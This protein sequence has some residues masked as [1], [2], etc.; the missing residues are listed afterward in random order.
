MDA[1][2]EERL[3]VDG[4]HYVNEATLELLRR[5]L[6][7]DVRRSFWSWVGLPVGGAGILGVLY[8]LFAAIP[9]VVGD[10]IAGDPSIQS[11]MDQAV[12]EYLR[13]PDAGGEL[14]RRQVEQSARPLVTRAVSGYLAS[15]EGREVLQDGIDEAVTA[16]YDGD[17]GMQRVR[18]LVREHMASDAVRGQIRSAVVTALQPAVARLSDRIEDNLSALVAEIAPVPVAEQLDKGSLDRLHRFLDSA[19]AAEIAA[20]G[21]PVTLGLG[22][23]RGPR[24]AAFAI[25]EH[26]DALR[27]RFGAAFRHVVITDRAGRFVALVDAGAVRA[28]LGPAFMEI[29]NSRPGAMSREETGQR[30]EALFGPGAGARLSTVQDAASAL[31]DPLWSGLEAGDPVPVVGPDGRFVGVTTRRGLIDGVLG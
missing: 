2:E 10:F 16:Y 29:V 11:R 14:I 6:E 13:D 1:D 5:R 28:R 18:A 21:R 8:V 24:Y 25:A 17:E 19:Q 23:G 27:D 9:N 20:A 31:R 4:G 15:G 26:I 30:I 3:A 22:A 7:A 12:V